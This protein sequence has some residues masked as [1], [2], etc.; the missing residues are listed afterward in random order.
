M[1]KLENYLHYNFKNINL[2]KTALTHRSVGNNNNERLEFLGDSFLGL[3][4]SEE[5]FKN[6]SMIDEGHLSRLRANLVCGKTLVEIAKKIN[7]SDFLILGKGE[8]KSAGFRKESILEDTIEAI[9]AA[10]FMDS[11]YKAAQKVVLF[12]YSD[13]LLKID[14]KEI[15]KD[16]KTQLQE[17]L[18]KKG[19]NLP[20]YK[21]LKTTGKDHNAVF[22]VECRLQ[23]EN[24]SAQ[25]NAK[26]IKIAEQ[27][28][29]KLLL[30]K[31]KNEF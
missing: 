31:L 9:I 1:K 3:V 8:L 14:E 16:F 29:A 19:S 20:F 30:Q 21:L 25:G 4:I 22:Y 12:L 11:G 17:L 24:I 2:L 6:F 18:Q 23:S 15:H 26:S 28:C 7:L 5:L 27:I 10:I 13:I